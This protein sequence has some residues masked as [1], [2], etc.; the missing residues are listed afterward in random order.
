[1]DDNNAFDRFL[2]GPDS[3]F[4]ELER[5]ADNSNLSEETRA[6]AE[7]YYATFNSISG[8]AVLADMFDRMVNVTRF[9]P[10]A[11]TDLAF[12]KEGRASVV[13]EIARMM[14]IAREGQ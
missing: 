14:Q 1:M 2:N 9:E 11:G 10:G 7:L 3:V 12:Y 13:H 8:R 6:R 4:S 5:I